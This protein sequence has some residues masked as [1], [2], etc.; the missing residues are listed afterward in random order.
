[1]PKRGYFVVMHF[2]LAVVSPALHRDLFDR[3]GV[4][5]ALACVNAQCTGAHLKYAMRI[6]GTGSEPGGDCTKK[7]HPAC[8]AAFLLVVVP[9]NVDQKLWRT[10]TP[11]MLMSLVFTPAPSFQSAE[12]KAPY[13]EVRLDNA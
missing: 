1:M 13:S 7:G 12:V 6:P 3:P 8:R 10:P 4:E 9:E 2:A 11:Q 5:A